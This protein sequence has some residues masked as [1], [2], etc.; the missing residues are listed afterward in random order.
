MQQRGLLQHPFLP[1]SLI[2]LRHIVPFLHWRRDSFSL[3]QQRSF[4]PQAASMA[5]ASGTER[6]RQLLSVAPM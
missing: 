6:S 1:Q 2:N 4:Q 5:D 3:K